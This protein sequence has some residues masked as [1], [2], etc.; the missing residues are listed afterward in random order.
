MAGKGG[1]TILQV[2]G[3]GAGVLVLVDLDIKD[4]LEIHPGEFRPPS[5]DKV[6][7][8]LPPAKE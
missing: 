8:P 4:M 3:G 1:G 2:L 6:G 5:R 7:L